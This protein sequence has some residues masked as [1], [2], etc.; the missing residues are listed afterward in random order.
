[1]GLQALTESLI[2]GLVP[3][4]QISQYFCVF[5]HKI[6]PKVRKNRSKYQTHASCNKNTRNC[7]S[8]I[9]N[10]TSGQLAMERGVPAKSRMKLFSNIW[11]IIE[12]N[13]TKITIRSCL[14]R[15][16]SPS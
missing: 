1:M 13:Q 2:N 12:I 10:D 4:C 11:S 8:A 7:G 9:G 14:I 16:F 15:T 6:A 5:F 3:R